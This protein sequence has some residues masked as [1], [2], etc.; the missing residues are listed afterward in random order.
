MAKVVKV[1]VVKVKAKVKVASK[2]ILLVIE[3]M[4]SRLSHSKYR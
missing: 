3:S 1:K 4:V 2:T